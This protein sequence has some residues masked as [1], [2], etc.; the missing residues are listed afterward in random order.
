[1]YIQDKMEKLAIKTGLTFDGGGT[2]TDY[3]PM[4]NCVLMFT[5]RP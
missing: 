5:L 4:M 2:I 3:L 1:M